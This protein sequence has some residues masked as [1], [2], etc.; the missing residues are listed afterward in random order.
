[1]GKALMVNQMFTEVT[2]YNE[3][4]KHFV[5]WEV[6]EAF[7]ISNINLDTGN[8]EHASYNT[9]KNM[10]KRLFLCSVKTTFCECSSGCIHPFT[11]LAST[12]FTHVQLRIQL[13]VIMFRKFIYVYAQTNLMDSTQQWALM[14]KVSIVLWYVSWHMMD[15]VL[16]GWADVVRCWFIDTPSVNSM[17]KIMSIA[18]Q[19]CIL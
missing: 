2:L 12:N 1:M 17:V 7:I 6:L 8:I 16:I 19:S 15:F 18:L 9:M 4:C 14:R 3:H 10:F 5:Y 11:Q 13:N